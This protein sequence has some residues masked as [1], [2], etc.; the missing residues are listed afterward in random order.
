MSMVEDFVH[1]YPWRTVA[2]AFLIGVGLAIDQRSR[3]AIALATLQIARALA[4]EQA[5]R[6]LRAW[7]AATENADYA[8][9]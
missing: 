5:R 3:R 8:R 6:Y 1:R 4:V 7:S 2:G 9:A